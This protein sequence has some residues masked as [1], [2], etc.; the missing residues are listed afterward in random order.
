MKKG[1]EMD[2]KTV[3]GFLSKNSPVILSIFSIAGV[4]STVITSS[5]DTLK[6][7]E[8]IEESRPRN[9]KELIRCTWKCYIPTAISASSTIACILG[10][11][12]CSNKQKNALASAYAVSQMTLQEY[13]KRVIDRIGKNKERGLMGEVTKEIANKRAPQAVFQSQLTDVIDTGHGRTLFYDVPGDKHFYSDMNY[14]DKQVND[15]N[16]EVRT[17]MYFDWNELRYRWGLPY[18]RYGSEL[19]FDVDRPLEVRYEPELMDNGQVRVLV[20][21]NLYPKGVKYE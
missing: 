3:K 21:Y 2:L 11:H 17:E 20:N 7:K 6:A 15:L 8:K 9:K 4:C 18:K 5:Q 14:M 10:S 12:Y 1:L 13:Q 19:I 16:R